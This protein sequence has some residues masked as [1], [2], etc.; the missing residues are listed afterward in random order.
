MEMGDDYFEPVW[1]A[2]AIGQV[3]GRTSRQVFHLVAQGRLPVRKNGKILQSTVGE[4]RDALLGKGPAARVE[5][6]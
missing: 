5:A 6:K 2:E 3:I 1:G 4:L